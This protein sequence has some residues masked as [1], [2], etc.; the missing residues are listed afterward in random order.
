MNKRC[1]DKIAYNTDIEAN[2][3][4]INIKARFGKHAREKRYYRCPVCSKY[5]L[6]S[7]PLRQ[8]LPVYDKE[9]RILN[10]V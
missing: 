2:V 1:V 5:H 7:E 4:L 3:V 10:L 9:K 8:K 6:T